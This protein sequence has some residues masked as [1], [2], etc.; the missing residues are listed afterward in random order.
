MTTSKGSPTSSTP[1][2]VLSWRTD[3]QAAM[4]RTRLSRALSALL[5]AQ[6]AATLSAATCG[7]GGGGGSDGDGGSWDATP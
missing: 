4:T 6:E 2:A 3:W 5:M 7:G 1:A